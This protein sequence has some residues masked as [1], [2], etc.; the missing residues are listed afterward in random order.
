MTSHPLPDLDEFAADA[1]LWLSSVAEPRSAAQWGVG[2]DSVAVFENWTVEEER[3]ET[4]RIRAYEQAKYDAGWGALTWPEEYGGRDL[5][6]S[7]ALSFRQEEDAFDVPRRT[8][9]FSVTQQLV[10]PAV[11]QWGTPEQRE[12]YVRAMLRTDLIAC[13]LF[14]ETEAGSDLAA[15]RTRAVEQPTRWTA[16]GCSTATRC[17]PPARRSPISASRSRA[18][19]RRCRQARRA[20]R[21]PGADGRPGRHRAADPPDDGRQLL[22]RGLP[23]RGRALRRPPAGSGRRRLEGRADRARRRAARLRQPRPGQRRPRRRARP[24][25]RPPAH[26]ARARPGRRPG[27]PQL[28]PAADGHAGG[29]GG[30][31]GT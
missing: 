6:T 27:G 11:A 31:L 29:R 16:T 28:R 3:A 23:R 13:Q 8:E 30:R 1:R 4:D 19:I 15:V 7:Y 24:P 12:R 20:H 25:P 9:M 18:P 17:G 14:S 22:Q 2:P 5:P 26:R 10:A 21:L